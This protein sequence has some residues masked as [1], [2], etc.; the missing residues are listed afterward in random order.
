MPVKP[1]CWK[2]DDKTF[3]AVH[4]SLKIFLGNPLAHALAPLQVATVTR[5]DKLVDMV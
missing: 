5:E 2:K 4:G 1:S 3:L